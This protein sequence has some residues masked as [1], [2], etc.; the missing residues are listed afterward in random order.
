MGVFENKFSWSKSR[1]EKFRECP[2]Q[3][4]YHHYGSWGGWDASAPAMT[5]ELYILKNLK[6]R[7][8]WV[9]EI[10]HHTIETA[11]KN[12]VTTRQMN[13]E[14]YLS[15]MTARMRKEFRESRDKNY[16]KIKKVVGLFEHEYES[17]IPDSK[18][19]E[20]HETAKRCLTNFFT[21]TFPRL[22]QPV[23]VENWKLIET[24]QEFDF[25][26]SLIY[27]K[28]DFAFMDQEGLK[29]V[30]WKTGRTEDVD[31]EIQLDCYGLFSKEHFKIPATSIKTVEANV[32]IAKENVRQMIE[33]K[34]DFAKHYLRNSIAGMK[35]VL[36]D[37]AK[38]IAEESNFPFTENEMTCRYCNF[39]KVC[40]KW[41]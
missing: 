32:N 28:I 41:R 23:P 11:L 38:N 29:I 10:V 8:M 36:K 18:W 7:H 22:V 14:K 40:A 3:Y 4:Y 16:R 12:Y 6:S 31:N 27:V 37:E 5:R 20:I 24:L 26:G 35:R 30:D 25:E 39:K 13:L 33:A 9:G 19:M 2:R 17:K 21:I 15:D 1:D 34:M